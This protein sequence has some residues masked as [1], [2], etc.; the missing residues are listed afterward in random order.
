[1][2][3]R[4]VLQHYYP[5]SF[6]P[7]KLPKMKV[8]TG[9]QQ[10]VRMALPMS[11]RCTACGEYLGRGKKFNSR[12]ETVEG[13]NYLGIKIYRFYMKCVRCSSEFTIRTN[14]EHHSYEAEFN[15]QRMQDAFRDKDN[16]PIKEVFSDEIDGEEPADDKFTQIERVMAASKHEAETQNKLD[17][18]RAL[19]AKR[20]RLTEA[21][22]LA[23]NIE[24]NLVDEESLKEEEEE[25]RQVFLK[26]PTKRIAEYDSPEEN[27]PF[28]FKRAKTS[29]LSEQKKKEDS[30][31]SDS[32]S[33]DSDSSS[34]PGRTKQPLVPY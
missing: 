30:G 12:K 28:N 13:E 9:G 22:V 1:M 25:I 29:T 19:N 23:S 24:S 26:A 6:D 5:P 31:D 27:L 4:K 14:P 16:K 17:E 3:E 15:C 10:E 33:S 2:G 20:N 21:E 11:V 34:S 18:L 8:T 32:E 7:S